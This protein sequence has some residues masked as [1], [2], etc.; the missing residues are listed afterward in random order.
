[1]LRLR[2]VVWNY[3]TWNLYQAKKVVSWKLPILVACIGDQIRAD[4]SL[5]ENFAFSHRNRELWVM[6]SDLSP[7]LAKNAFLS[8][9]FFGDQ[10]AK[11]ITVSLSSAWCTPD[12]RIFYG[13]FQRTG[14]EGRLTFV[15]ELKLKEQR[16]RAASGFEGWYVG[17]SKLAESDSCG[18]WQLSANHLD[19]KMWPLCW[20][21]RASRSDD[22]R[23]L[24]C[25]D[26]LLN[27]QQISFF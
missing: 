27:F 22:N 26:S 3:S 2:A 7:F 19:N 17:R 18:M 24:L 9:P 23:T 11:N 4:R 14:I 20:L 16:S 6:H 5:S 15:W 8:C 25:L 12:F 1:M 13:S 21:C 10:N